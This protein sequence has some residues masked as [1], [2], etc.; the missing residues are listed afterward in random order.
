MINPQWLELLIS[1]TNF[2]APKDVRAIEFRLYTSSWHMYLRGTLSVYSGH[3]WGIC[4]FEAYMH[5]RGRCVFG[6]KCLRRLCVP[7]I[8]GFGRSIRVFG[9]YAFSGYMCSR[10]ICLGDVCVFGEHAFS[11]YLWIR[12][13]YVPGI[14]V[15]GV[16][17]CSG[18]MHLRGICAFGVNV[19]S[20]RNYLR[21]TCRQWTQ[22][23]LITAFAVSCPSHWLLYFD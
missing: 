11:G 8:C 3:S 17:V 13:I 22:G 7:G 5:L 21:F 18:H 10:C 12:G 1:R 2:H 20:G 15:L 9:V 19:C 14:C 6:Y 23:S 16:Y 4:V